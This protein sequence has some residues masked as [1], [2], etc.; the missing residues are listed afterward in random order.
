[1]RIDGNLITELTAVP[2]RVAD[3]ERRGYDGAVAV[4]TNHD[5]FLPLLLAAEH[6]TRIELLT[7]VAIALARS[8]MTLAYTAYDLQRYAQ[9]RLILGLGSQTRPHIEK[10]FGM[11]W[12]APAARMREFI[13]AMRA[14]WSSWE[15]GERLEFRGEFYRHTLMT[16]FFSPGALECGP[17]RVFL[18]ALGTRMVEV[19]GEVADGILVHPMATERYIRTVTLPA[20]ER[21]LQRSGRA[22]DGFQVSLTPFLISGDDEKSMADARLMVRQQIAFYG[23]TPAYRCVLDLHG[24]GALQDELN[25]LSKQ[26]RWLEMGEL[27]SDEM[28]EAFAIEA[29][30]AGVAA[31]V[32]RRFGGLADRLS[33]YADWGADPERW[34]S[35]LDELRGAG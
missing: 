4:E 27:I 25:A 31:E 26:G 2:E 7:A 22:R 6:S 29:P 35:L 17:P 32:A 21:G 10:R 12:S 28:L 8:P 14:I 11:P 23:S 20:L 5:P 33:F 13:L 1:M 3:L 18:G 24:W 15:T 34:R 19:A 9:G 16:P 30:L